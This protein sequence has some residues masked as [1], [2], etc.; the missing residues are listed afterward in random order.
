MK[1]IFLFIYFA[2]SAVFVHAQNGY[3]LGGWIGASHYFGD[4][5]TDSKISSPGLAAGVLARYNWNE[6]VSLTGNIAYGR[7][8]A[9]DS[10][11]TNSYQ[12]TRN[13]S[14]RSYVLDFSATI[15]FNFFPYF[16]GSYDEYYTPYIFAGMGFSKFNP[17]AKLGNEWI[18]LQELGTEGQRS[19]EEYIKS[20]FALVYGMGFKFDIN[21]DWSVN[22]FVSGRR[23]MSDYLDDVSTTYP[24]MQRLE[25]L[26]GENA[27]MLSDRSTNPDF[28]KEGLQRGNNKDSDYYYFLGIGIVKYFGEIKCPK[29]SDFP[30]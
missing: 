20:S 29:I 5:N 24:N 23:L 30:K 18:D 12:K 27:V 6:R 26:R 17:Q 28:A 21:K 9:S 2:F 15:D 3:E 19:G 1:K 10:T 14:F 4:L 8:S 13:L 11:S 7:V 16:H 22:I 25:S